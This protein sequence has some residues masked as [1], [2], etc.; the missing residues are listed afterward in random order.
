MSDT[1]TSHTE[2]VQSNNGNL[3]KHIKPVFSENKIKYKG[4]DPTLRP[5]LPKLKITETSKAAVNIL[6]Q[7]IQLKQ[8]Q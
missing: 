8:K 5:S 1:Q 4:T 2:I 7:L 3:L 6:N